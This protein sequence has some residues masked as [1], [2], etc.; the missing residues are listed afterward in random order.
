[1]T[2]EKLNQIYESLKLHSKE[3]AIDEIFQLFIDNQ[4]VVSE[5]EILL[6]KFN[7][8]L[9]DDFHKMDKSEQ[10]KYHQHK[11]HLI[12]LVDGKE[13]IET[14]S[15]FNKAYFYELVEASSKNKSITKSLMQYA[16]QIC[17]MPI[18]IIT[19]QH[20]K[21]KNLDFFMQKKDFVD[22]IDNQ[23]FMTKKIRTL[24]DLYFYVLLSSN[25]AIPKPKKM[26]LMGQ[27]NDFFKNKSGFDLDLEIPFNN[28]IMF[29]EMLLSSLPRKNAN[30]IK[31]KFLC[32][33]P[34]YLN[35]NEYNMSL[36]N[37]RTLINKHYQAMVQNKVKEVVNYYNKHQDILN[38][39]PYNGYTSIYYS[40]LEEV[41]HEK[42]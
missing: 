33:K 13:T 2:T 40:L 21:V 37:P 15:V 30:T 34:T 39:F 29:I 24:Y 32:Y 4:L 10:K 35:D 14:Y 6:G 11:K 1:M 20:V 28:F 18:H 25:M 16:G 42:S 26:K 27:L 23:T 9:P 3:Y 8:Y 7:Y 22:I 19:M 31:M 5:L 17:S 12:H 38:S 36:E 41:K